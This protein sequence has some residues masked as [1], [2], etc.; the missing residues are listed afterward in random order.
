VSSDIVMPDRYAY[1][2]NGWKRCWSCY[3]L[4]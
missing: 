2:K 3:A 4:G 1:L